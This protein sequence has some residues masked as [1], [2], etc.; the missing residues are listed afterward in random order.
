MLFDDDAYAVITQTYQLW[1]N[2]L[3]RLLA[4][5]PLERSRLFVLAMYTTGVQTYSLP[6]P[7]NRQQHIRRLTEVY[8]NNCL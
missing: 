1:M 3:T 7:T 2:K 6:T 4:C 5:L 8:V